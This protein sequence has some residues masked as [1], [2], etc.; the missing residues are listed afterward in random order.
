MESANVENKSCHTTNA[1]GPETSTGKN[2]NGE[3]QDTCNG[4]HAFCCSEITQFY[5]NQQENKY[6]FTFSFKVLYTLTYFL[7]GDLIHE[8]FSN[9][10]KFP[11]DFSPPIEQ[12]VIVLVQSFLL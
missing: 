5:K 11:K 6:Q 12:D 9:N 2:C 10:L 3:K 8:E 1:S 4:V 7:F